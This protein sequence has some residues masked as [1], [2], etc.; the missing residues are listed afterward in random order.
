[1]VPE[2]VPYGTLEIPNDTSELAQ[3]YFG[4]CLTVVLLLLMILLLSFFDMY[5]VMVA[6]FFH[7]CT[8]TLTVVNA[9]VPCLGCLGR[10]HPRPSSVTVVHR[11]AG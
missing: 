9:E 4:W 2:T 6:H 3:P 1:M 10:G 5:C 7:T 11:L 8:S